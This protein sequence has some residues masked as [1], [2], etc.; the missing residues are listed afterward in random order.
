MY[1]YLLKKNNEFLRKAIKVNGKKKI[2]KKEEEG[3]K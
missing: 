2:K 1:I 3:V